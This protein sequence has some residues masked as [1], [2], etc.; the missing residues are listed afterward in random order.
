MIV[1]MTSH[2]TEVDISQTLFR[3]NPRVTIK[4]ITVSYSRL[5]LIKMKNDE[6]SGIVFI[7]SN[8]GYLSN[9]VSSKNNLGF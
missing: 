5:N 3:L 2:G 1:Y 7:S 6:I 4:T 9:L 8:N